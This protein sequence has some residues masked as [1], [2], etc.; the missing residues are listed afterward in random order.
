MKTLCFAFFLAACSGSTT[1]GNGGSGGAPAIDGL[2][3][4]TV[5]PAGDEM[6]FLRDPWGVAVQLVKRARPLLETA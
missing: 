5:T 4:I 2:V 1:G 6:V 3:Y